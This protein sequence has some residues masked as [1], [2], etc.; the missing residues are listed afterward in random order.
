VETGEKAPDALVTS[1]VDGERIHLTN[2][3][4]DHAFTVLLVD[5]DAPTSDGYKTLVG[6]ALAL[7]AR[8][9]ERVASYVVTHRNERPFEIPCAVRI[10]FD[11][12]RE[13]QAGFGAYVIDSD[14]HVTFR[15]EP[16]DATAVMAHLASV[17]DT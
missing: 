15:V 12:R 1:A 6:L 2:L 11:D 16:A 10:L 5:G 3:F 8:W 7:V 17:L 13:L 4:A 9:G 14:G